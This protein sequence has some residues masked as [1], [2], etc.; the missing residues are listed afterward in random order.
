M[1]GKKFFSNKLVKN[2]I[3]DLKKDK[4][5][6]FPDEDEGLNS[7]DS[8]DQYLRRFNESVEEKPEDYFLDILKNDYKDFYTF[9]R[10]RVRD[11]DPRPYGMIAIDLITFTV[12]RYHPEKFE[13]YGANLFDQQ[14]YID[15]FIK[16]LRK[17][18][19]NAFK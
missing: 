5:N 3:L 13:A 15:S 6:F 16:N 19:Q 9:L 18:Y 12:L 11:G 1:D 2:F 14:R 8:F 10:Y 17:D 7:A 4:L